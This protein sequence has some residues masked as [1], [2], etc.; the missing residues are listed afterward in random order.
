MAIHLN[1][2]EMTDIILDKLDILSV[3]N[4]HIYLHK[5]IRSRNYHCVRKLLQK[6]L[7]P[8]KTDDQ[9]SNTLHILFNSFTKELSQ[10][11]LIADELMKYK[12]R[13]NLLNKEQWAPIHIASR[14]AS[15]ECL[16]WIIDRNRINIISKKELFDFNLCGKSGWSP[17]HLAVNGYRFQESML[18]LAQNVHVSI[19]NDSKKTP[20]HVANGNYL[21]TKILKKYENIDFNFSYLS[22]FNSLNYNFSLPFPKYYRNSSGISSNHSFSIKHINSN[23]NKLNYNSL[24]VSTELFNNSITNINNINNFNN[25]NSIANELKV[26]NKHIT[27]HS[28]RP[29]NRVNSVSINLFQENNSTKLSKVLDLDKEESYS[30]LRKENNSSLVNTMQKANN[31]IIIKKPNSIVN[32]NINGLN[33]SSYNNNDTK[34]KDKST[35]NT[36]NANANANINNLS[37]NVNNKFNSYFND[38]LNMNENKKCFFKL[39]QDILLISE[40]EKSIL[41]HQ[42]IILNNKTSYTEKLDSLMKLK[43]ISFQNKAQTELIKAFKI[44]LENLDCCIKENLIIITEILNITVSKKLI[45]LIPFLEKLLFLY[46]NNNKS[47]NKESKTNKTGINNSNTNKDTNNEFNSN[48]I[49]DSLININKSFIVQSE[50]ENSIKILNIIKENEISIYNISKKPISS[51]QY[52]ANQ[53][54][55][56]VFTSSNSNNSMSNVD[57][58]IDNSNNLNINKIN[59]SEIMNH[60]NNP[61]MNMNDIN[62][63]F[64]YLNKNS[65]CC[66]QDNYFNNTLSMN[67]SINANYIN[68]KSYSI[69]SELKKDNLDLRLI[70]SVTN[71]NSNIINSTKNIDIKSNLNIKQ[72]YVVKKDNITNIANTNTKTSKKSLNKLN[73]LSTSPLVKPVKKLMK[74]IDV[75][76]LYDDN[77]SDEAIKN[78]PINKE[79]TNKKFIKDLIEGNKNSIGYI[80]KSKD[81]V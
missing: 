47:S 56:I 54:A 73:N 49:K 74:E 72:T 6:G 26:K 8:D 33:K 3:K 2:N 29:S 51:S 4:N 53:R 80:R 14:R 23:N 22:V 68:N 5:A 79:F 9:G 7:D 31:N 55:H 32:I 48:N 20:K 75:D 25:N 63:K 59:N 67:S 34:A 19:K 18:I 66:I 45:F 12:I 69:V 15:I 65:N 27:N 24:N 57:C 70:N 17:L 52:S 42:E 61:S 62:R 36:N 71:M 21:M 35:S 1:N 78:S 58:T 77:F 10:C 39:R 43:L 30:N 64:Y 38:D 16:H 13:L 81:D 44:I 40:E 41:F 46:K 76:E 50:V 37:D 60:S 11:A 28:L